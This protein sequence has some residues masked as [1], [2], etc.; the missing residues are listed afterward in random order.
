MALRCWLSLTSPGQARRTLTER[1][2]SL[3]QQAH[4]LKARDR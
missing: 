2:G 4:S 3:T 1:S